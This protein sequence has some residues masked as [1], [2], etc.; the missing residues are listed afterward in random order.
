MLALGDHGG[1]GGGRGRDSHAGGAV[2]AIDAGARL[3]AVAAQQAGVPGPEDGPGGAAVWS[4]PGLWRVGEG[5][6]GGVDDPVI[7]DQRDGHLDGLPHPAPAF[8]ER[9]D[10]G[11]HAEHTLCTPERVN[12]T[13]A[14]SHW[15][16][17]PV[18]YLTHM[19]GFNWD[20][21]F[22]KGNRKIVCCLDNSKPWQRREKQRE[23]AMLLPL[24]H[25]KL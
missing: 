5:Q 18:Y 22:K 7:P 25:W 17:R 14:H 23:E 10:V 24:D 20:K 6:R 13:H 9:R 21:F 8:A 15:Q 16:K 3:L 11:H 12:R 4:R 2:R 1:G 19:R